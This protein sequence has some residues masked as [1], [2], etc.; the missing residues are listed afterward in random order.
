MPRP[1][2]AANGNGVSQDRQP[3]RPV[4]IFN[5]VAGQEAAT[6]ML[7]RIA[8]RL[9]NRF[10]QLTIMVTQPDVHAEA[11]AQRALEQGADLVVA[12]CGWSGWSGGRDTVALAGALFR[13]SL[14]G[15]EHGTASARVLN[16]LLL[17]M[18]G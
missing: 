9:G 5:P 16:A 17:Q 4:L 7:G 8:L 3:Q 6:D 1:A 10:P 13:W 11:L 2:A 12:R 18:M 15:A 14:E